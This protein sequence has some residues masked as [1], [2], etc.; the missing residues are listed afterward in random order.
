MNK[1]ELE[2]IFKKV[3]AKFKFNFYEI[4][5]EL[6]VYITF[7]TMNNRGK[8]L[9]NLELLKNRLIYLATML[10]IDELTRSAMRKDINETWKTI[11]AYLGKNKHNAMDDDEFLRNHWIMYFQYNRK[12]ADA[13]AKYLLN[14]EFTTENINTKDI[15]LEDIQKYIKSLSESVK[16]WFYLHNPQFSEYTDDTKEWLQKLNRLGMSAFPPLVYGKYG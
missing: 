16:S 12:E 10:E 7:A 3:T 2:K 1:S 8:P 4:D 11:Y 6:D 14:Q 5:E 9:S 13:Y 15:V